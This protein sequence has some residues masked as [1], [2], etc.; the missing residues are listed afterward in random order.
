MYGISVLKIY[1][2]RGPSDSRVG[3][4]DRGTLRAGSQVSKACDWPSGVVLQ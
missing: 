3:L 1:A 4:A 2:V